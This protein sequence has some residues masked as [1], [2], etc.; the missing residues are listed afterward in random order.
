[1][2]EVK[3][4]WSWLGLIPDHAGGPVRLVGAIPIPSLAVPSD[5]RRLAAQGR[6]RPGRPRPARGRTTS[7]VSTRWTRTVVS[8]CFTTVLTNPVLVAHTS[9]SQRSSP[10]CP[11][12]QPCRQGQAVRS[13]QPRCTRYW[14]CPRHSASCRT[15]PCS[16]H[17]GRQ[18]VWFMRQRHNGSSDSR[19]SGPGLRVP[20]LAITR[21]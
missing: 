13:S 15:D 14:P 4:H 16:Y 9:T 10:P 19:R 11:S 18:M 2:Q 3:S 7:A 8:G 12:A 21:P 1:M 6:V 20:D 5:R 17:C